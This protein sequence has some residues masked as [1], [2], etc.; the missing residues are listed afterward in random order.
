[1]QAVGGAKDG[2]MSVQ[3]VDFVGSH[4]AQGINFYLYDFK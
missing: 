2:R 3:R 1:M 4:M